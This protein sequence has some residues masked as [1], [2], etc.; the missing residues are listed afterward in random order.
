MSEGAPDAEVK[1]LLDAGI[2]SIELRVLSVYGPR[3]SGE[4]DGPVWID[5]ELVQPPDHA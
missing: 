1:L 5:V 4:V 2:G 3:T